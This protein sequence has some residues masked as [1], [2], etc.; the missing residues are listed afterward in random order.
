MV[1]ARMMRKTPE[2]AAAGASLRC[3]ALAA[4]CAATSDD[5]H[6]VCVARHGP[7]HADQL[8]QELSTHHS[9]ILPAPSAQD[10]GWKSHAGYR[11]YSLRC[12]KVCSLMLMHG[13]HPKRKHVS[14]T[15]P[16]FHVIL[17][18]MLL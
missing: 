3:S 4:R 7:V 6:A 2:A 18:S 17:T 1:P 13:V 8:C 15:C 16:T 9:R 14:L 11:M 12:A 5:E 10:F